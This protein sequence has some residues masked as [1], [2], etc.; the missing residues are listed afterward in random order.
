MADQAASVIARLKK[1]AQERGVPLQLL[2]NLFC[3]E[4]FLRRISNSAY[5][6]QLILKGGLLLYS[7]SR[8]ESRPTMDADYL[9]RRHDNDMEKIVTMVQR[10]IDVPSNNEFIQFTIRNSE[11]ISEHR[12][13]NGVRINLIG[14]IKTTRTPFSVD[15]GI[16]DIVV[17][18]PLHRCLPVLLSDFDQPEVLT[19]SLES[20]IAE[21]F[22]A[23]LSRMELTSRMKDFFDIYYLASTYHFEGRKLQEAIQ[24]TLEN[25]RT[26]YARNSLDR[27]SH[28]HT[29]RDMITKWNS[30]NRKTLKLSLNF[31]DVLNLITIF[32]TAP[33][34]AVLNDGECFEVWD[35]DK[36]AWV[37]NRDINQISDI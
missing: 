22:D 21:K 5:S 36:N 19:Y 32:L 8:F 2:L 18:K 24:Q 20:T 3:Q 9:L 10:I 15:F 30:F 14:T 25:R 16:G 12:Q 17:P 6:D 27:I 35:K 11:R 37:K 28:F 7:L 1:Q 26:E 29:D 13:Y 4:E 34:A 23:I 33:F 31:E